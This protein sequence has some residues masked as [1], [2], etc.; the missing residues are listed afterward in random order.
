MRALALTAAAGPERLAVVELP[1]PALT[2]PDQ[3]RIR[4]RA[5]ALNHLDLFVAAGLPGV[6]T[7]Y[8]HVVGADG[9]GEVD[10]V[11]DA[12]RDFV[13]GDR[14]MINPGLSCGDCGY[15]RAGE[16]SCCTRFALL[17]EHR[18]GAAAEY[19]V[20][21]AA[22]LARVPGAM[23]WP[24]AAAFSLAT[25]TAWRMLT[26]RARVQPG[27][28]VLVWGAGGGVALAA[29]RIGA[30]LG[31]RIIATSGS[32]A[33]LAA[34]RAAGAVEALDHSTHDVV[35]GVR[36]L[37]GGL[38]AD[39]VVDSVGE[40]TWP[41]SLRA[42]R[43][44]GRLVICGATT[45]PNVSLDLRRLFWHQ[46]SIL[47]STMG[48]RR[49]YAEIVRLAHEGKLWPAVDR[50]V[51]LAAGAEAFARLAR[52]EQTGKLVIEVAA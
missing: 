45:G 41:A 31:A 21:P 3:V 51:P 1:V 35:A 12:V 28:S 13:P 11:G 20:L 4:M 32:A 36:A 10:A 39:V 33:K 16:E 23:P 52:G 47:G 6:E 27:E 22:N 43:R 7:T 8:P 46:W 25:L 40:R 30:L 26:T 34:A 49:E 48:T 2:A 9:A 5:A 18:G 15:C 37:T 17:G 38:G 42:M 29:I 19:V 44:G 50:V 14:V 24:Q